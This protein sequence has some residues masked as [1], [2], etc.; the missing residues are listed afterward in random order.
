MEETELT[1]IW[2]TPDGWCNLI[3]RFCPVKDYGQKVCMD[4]ND[5]T[6]LDHP[7]SMYYKM[8]NKK[9]IVDNRKTNDKVE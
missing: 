4:F 2:C 5:G 7:Q 3:S 8:H 6:R 1:C 9:P